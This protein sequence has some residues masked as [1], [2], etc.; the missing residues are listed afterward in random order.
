[1]DNSMNKFMN[2][3][4]RHFANH[5]VGNVIISDLKKLVPTYKNGESS[6]LILDRYPTNTQSFMA[7]IQTEP[8]WDSK[9][10]RRKLLQMA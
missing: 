10:Q 8:L 9:T 5:L 6:Y 7:I 3:K 2:K 4:E 1:M